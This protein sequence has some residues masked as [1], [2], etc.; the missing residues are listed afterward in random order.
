MSGEVGAEAG[1]GARGHLQVKDKC[2]CCTAPRV[3]C[4][5]CLGWWVH[6]KYW[7]VESSSYSLARFRPR[8]GAFTCCLQ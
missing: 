2:D 1:V 3:V 6:K 7:E 4:A 5:L 8:I